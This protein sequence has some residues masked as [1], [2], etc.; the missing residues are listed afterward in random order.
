M[1]IL[2]RIWALVG[3]LAWWRPQG[4]NVPAPPVRERFGDAPLPKPPGSGRSSKV[5]KSLRERRRRRKV[6]MRIQRE[7]RRRNRA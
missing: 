6:L 3:A 5:P 4:Q 2:A 1:N 7:S